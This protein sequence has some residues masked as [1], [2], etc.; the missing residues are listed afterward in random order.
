MVRGD[1][2][3]DKKVTDLFSGFRS[4]KQA[5]RHQ[6]SNSCQ[7][8]VK[9]D[10]GVPVVEPQPSQVIQREIHGKGR[11]NAGHRPPAVGPTPD[12]SSHQADPHVS[13]HGFGQEEGVKDFLD[14]EQGVEYAEHGDTEPA[15]SPNPEIVPV[16]AARRQISPIEALSEERSAVHHEGGAGGHVGR[17]NAGDEKPQRSWKQK[18]VTGKTEGVFGVAEHRARHNVLRDHRGRD[19]AHEGPAYGA[20]SLDEVAV[21]HAVAAGLLIFPRAHGGELMGLHHDS[22]QAVDRQH[23]DEPDRDPLWR[24]QAELIGFQAGF[25]SC[26]PAHDSPAQRNQH[27]GQSNDEEALKEIGPRRRDE[28]AEET[29]NDKNDGHADHDLVDS[30]LTAGGLADDLA[31]AF[32]HGAHVDG[33]V[34]YGK[35]RIDASHPHAV[36]VLEHLGH[37]CA[38]EAPEDGRHDPVKGRD[39]QVLPLKPDGGKTDVID[40]PRERNRHLGMCPH[41]ET[42]AHHEPLVEAAVSEK[43]MLGAAHLARHVNPDPC[44]G[45]EVEEK[46][47]PVE[48]GDL[49]LLHETL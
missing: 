9:K 42:L 40:R 13:S 46:N 18:V 16:L 38:P 8:R 35:D 48:R 39:E 21:S 47:D 44:H 36:A 29:V 1:I 33:E 15:E 26:H 49:N 4:C 5:H 7:Q 28:A 41:A 19:Q 20:E 45:K 31:G 11:D 3:A 34:E 2:H 22:N 37:G 17:K 6:R 43:V 32:E 10:V 23:Q 25:H 12:Q 30:H 27:E 14:Q 24:G